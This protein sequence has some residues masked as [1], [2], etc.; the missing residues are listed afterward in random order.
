MLLFNGFNRARVIV[1]MDDGY[2]IN[3]SLASFPACLVV[4]DPLP[5]WPIE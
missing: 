4:I 2:C 5:D 3:K 1:F